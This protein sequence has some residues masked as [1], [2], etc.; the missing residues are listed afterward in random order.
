MQESDAESMAQIERQIFSRPWT[1]QNFL[2]SYALADTFY[3]VA[4]DEE[5]R[6]AGYC[7]C[8]Q[9]FE[10]GNISNVAVTPD[11]RRCGIG[12]ALIFRLLENGKERGITTFS[13]E[14]RV[15]NEPAIRLYE[16]HGFVTEGVRRR[17]YADPVEDA[18]IMLYHVKPE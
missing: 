15:S 14:V 7:G 3:L 12:D 1:K 11:R 18:G 8:Y 13:L 6:L 16:K 5:G 9:S 10:E 4:E 2:E 17:F